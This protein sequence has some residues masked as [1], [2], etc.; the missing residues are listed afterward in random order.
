MKV[1]K[2]LNI[3]QQISFLVNDT[4]T[5]N[6]DSLGYKKRVNKWIQNI[7]SFFSKITTLMHM[8]WI[9]QHVDPLQGNGPYTYNIETRRVRGDVTQQRKNYKR[10]SLWVRFS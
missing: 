3:L 2:N 5:V 8:L 6:I 10:C 1:L 9:L 4:I 7:N